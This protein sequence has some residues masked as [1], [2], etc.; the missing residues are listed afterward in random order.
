M[1]VRIISRE[2]ALRDLRGVIELRQNIQRWKNKTVGWLKL[3]FVSS[4]VFGW[5]WFFGYGSNPIT[6][7]FIQAV[8]VTGGGIM[9]ISSLRVLAANGA[10]WSSVRQEEAIRCY[11]R[12]KYQITN[13]ELE[14]EL[15]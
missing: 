13:E 1:T 5:I 12:E 6:K 10:L 4:Y 11:L 9:L 2:E 15:D 7:F 8:T 3:S 14:R